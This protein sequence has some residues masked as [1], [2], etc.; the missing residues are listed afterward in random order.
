M[1]DVW[2]F[3]PLFSLSSPLFPCRL[4]FCPSLCLCHFHPTASLDFLPVLS[5]ISENNNK[6]LNS[7][8]IQQ[9]GQS[10]SYAAAPPCKY[11]DWFCHNLTR[12]S[13]HI[14]R[15]K[16]NVRKQLVTR[17]NVRIHN[18]NIHHSFCPQSQPGLESPSSS[19]PAAPLTPPWWRDDISVTIHVVH[20]EGSHLPK[21]K[22]EVWTLQQLP[23]LTCNL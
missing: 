11:E 13:S 7:V 17:Q 21:L 14:D 18:D 22:K 15:I 1:F 8:F 20:F 9:A 5:S 6:S 10:F 12:Y 4:S 2:D 16:N 19:S 23:F 3:T